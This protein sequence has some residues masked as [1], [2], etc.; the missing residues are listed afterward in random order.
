MV[1][2]NPISISQRYDLIKVFTTVLV[3]FGH[4]SRMYTG[5]GVITPANPSKFLDLCTAIIYAFHMPLYICVSGMVYGFCIDEL[6]KYRDVKKFVL[7][8][9]KR[10][11]IP[12]LFWGI[13]YVAPIMV[14]FGF[15]KQS[16]LQYAINLIIGKDSR[17]LWF[18]LCLFLIFIVCAIYRE[19]CRIFSFNENWI[20]IL[21]I[22]LFC[23]RMANHIP[24]ILCINSLFQYFIWFYLGVL[25]NRYSN[26]YLNVLISLR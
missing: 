19:I 1:K 14:I 23:N 24:N 16:Y 15:T 9:T 10:L 26:R 12:Y 7:T 5:A 18:I 22:G 11:L 3:V 25:I 8:K 13:F 21:L 4:A 20:V 2:K 17:H 6:G